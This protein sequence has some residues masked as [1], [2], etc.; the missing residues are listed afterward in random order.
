METTRIKEIVDEI[1]TLSMTGQGADNFFR[2]KYPMFVELYPKLY[3]AALD[4]NFPL[5][6]LDFMLQQVDLLKNNA[7]TIEGADKI[8]YDHLN[9]AFIKPVV[10]SKDV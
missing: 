2:E 6:Y 7:S 3:K 8:I 1:R 4:P 10:G 9:D 5:K